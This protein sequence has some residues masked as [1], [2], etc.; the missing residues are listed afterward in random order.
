MRFIIAL[1]LLFFNLVGHGQQADYILYNGKIFTADDKAPYVEALVIRK[2]R[3]AETGTSAEVLKHAGPATKRIDLLGKT[4]IP[5]FNDAHMH[6]V[7]IYK[8]RY[9]Q[10]SPDGTGSPTRKVFEDSIIKVVNTLPKGTWI[11]AS[12]GPATIND[13]SLNRFYLD[14]IAPDHP[15][16]LWSFW[17]HVGVFNSAALKAT[18]LLDNPPEI[19]AGY[20]GRLQNNDVLDGRIYDNAQ[21]VSPA[22]N[23]LTDE[24]AF[25]TTLKELGKEALQNGVTSLQNM[26]TFASPDTYVAMWKK[27]GLP[28]RFRAISWA[29]MNRS[30]KLLI[31]LS[32]NATHPDGLP[33]MTISGTKWMIEGTP[34]EQNAYYKAGYLR[35]AGWH[36]IIYH[37][38][39]EIKQ[40]LQDAIERRQQPMF[41]ITGDSMTRLFLDAM[42]ELPAGMIKKLRVRIEHGDGITHGILQDLK[43][44]DVIV[45]V[46]P[47][48]PS[49]DTGIHFLNNYADTSFALVKSLLTAGIRTAI[50]SDGPLNPFLNIM[51]AM[52]RPVESLSCE[53]A[54]I[55]YTKTAAYAEFAEADKGT[56][57]KGKVADLVVLSQ[58]IFTVQ[59]SQLMATKVLLTMVDGKIAFTTNDIKTISAQK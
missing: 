21:Y 3:I 33:L 19:K 17:G 43:N 46:N 28:I 47:M 42:N 41:H 10:F 24:D 30:G 58:D 18:N 44:K 34:I 57:E 25:T 54:V 15:I 49:Q 5:G 29:D 2:N 52:V 38:Q 36:G 7:P 56:L 4:V 59:P 23:Q 14:K 22:F 12:L 9:I 55:A 11:H 35:P 45:V 1:S 16:H 37:T 40:M 13:T 26:C 32:K 50:G 27:A 39:P 20:Y 53:E 8:G 48:H 6:H 31:P 51:L